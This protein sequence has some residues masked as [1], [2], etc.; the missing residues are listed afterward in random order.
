MG[1]ERVRIGRNLW[2][3]HA[4]LPADPA[5][6]DIAP[7]M[8]GGSVLRKGRALSYDFVTCSGVWKKR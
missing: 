7:P 1:F 2:N 8:P 5:I 4:I 6:R 3:G